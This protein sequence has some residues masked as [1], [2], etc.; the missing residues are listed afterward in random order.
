MLDTTHHYMLPKHNVRMLYKK[1]EHSPNI[2]RTLQK[3]PN[4]RLNATTIT[5]FILTRYLVR[6]TLTRYATHTITSYHVSKWLNA[7]RVTGIFLLG[8]H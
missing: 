5:G 4:I 7:T 3:L 8:G 1:T 6:D 2:R